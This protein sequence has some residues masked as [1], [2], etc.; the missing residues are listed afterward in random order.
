MSI[1]GISPLGTELGPFG[2]PGLLTVLGVLVSRTN[3]IIVVWDTEPVHAKTARFDSAS[4]FENY[5]LSVV[6]P[7]IVASDGTEILPKGKAIATRTP[8][9]LDAAQDAFD[10]TQTIIDLD[11]QM[12]KGVDYELSIRTR[13]RGAND[14]VFAG[15]SVF[16]YAGIARRRVVSAEPPTVETT[17]DFAT[18]TTGLPG[19]AQGFLFDPN[20]DIATDEGDRFLVKRVFRRLLSEPGAFSHLPN[21]GLGFSV[22]GLFKPSVMQSLASSATAQLRQEP[23]VLNA[24]VTLQPVATARGLLVRASIF[25]LRRGQEEKR[26]LYQF[27]PQN[28]VQLT[29]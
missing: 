18:V 4:S 5:E 16:I 7:L 15:P 10:T 29:G 3:Q 1:Y 13:I 12:E 23:D 17:K 9:I 22:K 21:Y 27:S 6:S 8:R 25:L 24:A 28:Q 20:N 11:A 2:G 14:E 26:I 19:E